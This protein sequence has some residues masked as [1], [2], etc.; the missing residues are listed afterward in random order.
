VELKV[1]K[2]SK[3]IIFQALDNH[4]AE[5]GEPPQL[6]PSDKTKYYAY[7]EGYMQEQFIFVYDYQTHTGLLWHSTK[8]LG[9]TYAC[10]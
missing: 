2:K 1:P 7:F 8:G 6:D 9:S 3:K 5:S 10:R 4:S